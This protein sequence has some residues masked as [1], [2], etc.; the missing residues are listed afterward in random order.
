LTPLLEV[1]ELSTHFT[2]GG[3]AVPAV[4]EVS[5]TVNRGEMVGL[6]GESGCGKSVTALSVLRLVQDPPGRIAGG[7]VLLDGR[8]LLRMSEREL[9]T[10]RGGRIAMVFQDPFSSL[11]PTMT[12][13]AQIMEAIRLHE[14]VGRAEARRRTVELLQ[15]VRIPSP[16]QCMRRYPHEVSGGQRQRVMIAMAFA[17]HPD[18]IIAD[19]PTTALDVT[20]QAQV[21]ALMAD[22]RQRTGAAI[23]LITHDLGIVAETCDRVL[24][25]YAGR[26]VEEGAVMDMFERPLHPYTQGLLR[27]L[28]TMT[29]PRTRRLPSIPGQPPVLSELPQGCAFADRCPQVTQVC[30]L[31]EPPRVDLGNGAAVRCVFYSSSNEPAGAEAGPSST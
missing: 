16:E 25:M 3:R 20:V 14:S 30:R 29:G 31:A 6:V 22:L 7:E 28:P 27:S 4:R 23:V 5:F 2:V 24:V 12:L 21:L 19:E 26:I 11:N 8:D 15:S 13:G 9:R 17:A 1:R 18:L 10:I